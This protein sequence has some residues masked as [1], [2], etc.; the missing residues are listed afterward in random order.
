MR[1]FHATPVLAGLMIVAAAVAL[2]AD[3]RGEECEAEFD[4]TFALIEKVIFENRGCTAAAC[5][6]QSAQ[7][8]LVLL[9]G[10]AYDELIDQPVE[11]IPADQVPGLRRVVPARKDR[12]LLWLNVA[13]AT[14]PDLWTAPKQPMPSEAA[15]SGTAH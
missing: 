12:S 15:N 3:A 4:S 11:S 1:A 14:L 10:V 5:H 8:G 6:G 9:P 7:G 2:P 13:A